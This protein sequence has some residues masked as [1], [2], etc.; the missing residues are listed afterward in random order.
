MC[1]VHYAVHVKYRVNFL[2]CNLNQIEIIT[3]KRKIQYRPKL[4]DKAAMM[5]Q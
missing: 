1:Y 5:L 4:H 3:V 2:R